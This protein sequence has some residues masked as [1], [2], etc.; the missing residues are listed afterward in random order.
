MLFILRSLFIFFPWFFLKGSYCSGCRPVCLCH[1]CRLCFVLIAFCSVV[2]KPSC[3]SP[4]CLSR[5]TWSVPV[6]EMSLIAFAET[7]IFSMETSFTFAG[8]STWDLR[9]SPFRH[10]DCELFVGT[11]TAL[12]KTLN[13]SVVVPPRVVHLN[14]SFLHFRCDSSAWRPGPATCGPWMFSWRSRESSRGD[15]ELF[16]R[17]RLLVTGSLGGEDVGRVRYRWR[18]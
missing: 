6:F 7:L 17:K 14:V 2:V 4:P 16:G 13:A 10:G 1:H 8:T 15:I 9:F 5:E 18:N 3:P 11:A 12:L